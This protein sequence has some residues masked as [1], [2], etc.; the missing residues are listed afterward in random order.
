FPT[1][2]AVSSAKYWTLIATP[3][4]AMSASAHRML[5]KGHERRHSPAWRG[6]LGRRVELGIAHE[7]EVEVAHLVRS[8]PL[9]VPLVE[10]R[11][12]VVVDLEVG[13]LTI[14]ER[15][16]DR[17]R[18]DRRGAREERAEIGAVLARAR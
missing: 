18:R 3:R 6:R 4:V 7:R 16:V 10:E 13:D 2:F 17:A 12:R 5:K 15:V 9:E 11:L 14:E 1:L 8:V